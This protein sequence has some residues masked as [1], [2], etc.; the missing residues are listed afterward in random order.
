MDSNMSVFD[1]PT[2]LMLKQEDGMNIILKIGIALSGTSSG[3]VDF[4]YPIG[5]MEYLGKA[6][7]KEVAHM[8][9][10]LSKQ[11]LEKSV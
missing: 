8:L 5:V 1:R 10:V 6:R 4:S 2:E 11:F 3:E 9:E 7:C